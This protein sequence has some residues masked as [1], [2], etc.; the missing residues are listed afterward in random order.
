MSPAKSRSRSRHGASAAF[1]V[2]LAAGG[3]A[4]ALARY[5]LAG[6]L[7]DDH[8]PL[9]TFVVNV[10]GCL[11]L[12]LLIVLVDGRLAASRLARPLLATGFVGAYT[13]FSTLAVEAVLLAH[14]GDWLT[15]LGYVAA[16]MSAG[17]AAVV[18]GTVVG[19]RLSALAGRRA[20]APR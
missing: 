10:S 19:R 9:G 18:L 2:A 11:V 13:T 17:L 1:Y 20:G 15:G 8:F 4:G 7:P 3:A 12:G 5:G 14:S 16:S 6:A